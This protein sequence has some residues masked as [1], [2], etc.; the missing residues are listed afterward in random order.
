MQGITTDETLYYRYEPSLGR[1]I[2]PFW[3]YEMFRCAGYGS[4]QNLGDEQ[5]VVL[6]L[7]EFV[8]TKQGDSYEILKFN[9]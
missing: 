7:L 6:E 5:K 4:K 9:H 2:M 1:C 8:E 3:Y